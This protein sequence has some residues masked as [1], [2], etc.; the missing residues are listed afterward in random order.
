MKRLQAPPSVTGI[1]TLIR[2]LPAVDGRSTVVLGVGGCLSAALPIVVTILT[3]RLIGSIPATA[4][5]GFGSP[6]GH[7]TVII[8]VGITAF[9]VTQRVVGPLLHAVGSVLGRELEVYLQE[10][11][12]G[13]VVQPAGVSHL[14][15]SSVLDLLRVVRGFG[16][17]ANRPSDAVAALVEVIPFWIQSV[18][19]FIVLMFFQ[20]WLGLAWLVLWPFLLHLLQREYL[21]AGEV[22]YGQ[23]TPLRRAEYLR[24]L[25]ITPQAAK[26]LRIW[27]MRDWLIA[28]F[29]SVWFATMEPVWQARNF[30]PR[31]TWGVSAVLLVGNLGS[32]GLLAW[33][34]THGE[35]GL[36]ALA[37]FTQAM[38][39]AASFN[40]FNDS[41][42]S[43][44]FGAVAVP[45]V[46]DLERTL[47]NTTEAQPDRNAPAPEQSITFERVRFRYPHATTYTYDG[48]DLTI[49][50]GHSLAIVG[51]NGA[52][53]S[54][55]IKLLCG[56]YTPESGGIR[57]DDIPLAEFDPISWQSH[58]AV[59]FQDFARYHL[60]V[61]DNIGLGAPHLAGDSDRIQAAAEKAGAIELIESL[62]NGWDTVL[63]RQ[64]AD[65]TDLSGGQWQRIALARALFAVE[66]GARV[67]VLDE[68]T[69]ALD[70]RA[71]AELYDRFL[72]ITAGLTTILISHRFSTVRRAER[73][74]VL[75]NG[76][77]R[78]D[79][80]HDELMAD[81]G[82]Y[83][84]MF[85]LQA[86]H[87][88]AGRD[89]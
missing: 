52:G 4:Q 22:G 55:L 35:I 76:R 47:A 60:N 26:E 66:A 20:W 40:A 44:M 68:P 14:E 67:L 30:S 3:G 86:A 88:Q 84:E 27:G 24:D 65:G 73:I 61:S 18:L 89:A 70:V 38:G 29:E 45:K 31:V 15:D 5:G 75:H 10:R 48:L 83:A 2:L 63:S 79:G 81:G 87:F 59:L 56:L 49:H 1:A 12:I 7:A 78:E 28:K 23:S 43:L 51:E 34:G 85:S 6:A 32:Y 19:S 80:S 33:A 36:G 77:I 69:A 42:A 41:N 71:E 17:D 62:P 82:R 53:K 13:A 46:G 16:T 39:N 57:I 74:V 50:A 9:V 25:A 37:V 11:V 58:I 64:Y 54:T 21:R 72:D 8:L